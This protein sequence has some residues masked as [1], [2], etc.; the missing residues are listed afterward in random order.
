MKST[1]VAGV[2]EIFDPVGYGVRMNP[3]AP[4]PIPG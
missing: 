3:I 1:V 2:K 4:S